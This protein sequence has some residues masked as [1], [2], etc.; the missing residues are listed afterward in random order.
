MYSQASAVPLAQ[1]PK[2]NPTL[3]RDFLVASCKK[4]PLLYI[5]IYTIY[6]LCIFT[7]APT[8]SHKSSGKIH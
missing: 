1:D 8:H 2:G 4:I 5:Y 7:L 3:N 6:I